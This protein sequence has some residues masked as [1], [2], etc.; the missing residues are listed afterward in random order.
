MWI[1]IKCPGFEKQKWAWWICKWFFHPICMRWLRLNENP[2][3]YYP[4]CPTNGYRS[5]AKIKEF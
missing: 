4:R 5:G 1:D 3:G 2:D